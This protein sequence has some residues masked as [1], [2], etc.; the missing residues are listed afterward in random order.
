MI[1]AK[2]FERQRLAADTFLENNQRMLPA[3]RPYLLIF[4]LILVFFGAA[5]VFDREDVGSVEL[6][7]PTGFHEFCRIRVTM[8][9]AASLDENGEILKPPAFNAGYAPGNR[10]EEAFEALAAVHP[11]SDIATRCKR[12]RW[13]KDLSGVKWVPLR[14]AT[15]SL[16]LVSQILVNQDLVRT[17]FERSTGFPT[18]MLGIKKEPLRKSDREVFR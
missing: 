6:P 4:L 11:A 17:R 13:L 2:G 3:R 12:P 18:P 1:G 8:G 9:S 10:I 15:P 14:A 16:E 7:T 5:F